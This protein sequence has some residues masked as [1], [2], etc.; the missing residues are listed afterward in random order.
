MFYLPLAVICWL[1]M[2]WMIDL[3][4]LPR[5]LP[6]GLLGS[7]LATVHDRMVISYKLWEYRDNGWIDH[8]TEIAL[9]ISFSA[10]PIFGMRFAERL[11]HG[12]PFPW[13]R[14]LRYTL[15]AM[16]PEVVALLTGR[17][18]YHGWWN[19]TWSIIAYYPIWAAFWGL[20]RWLHTPATAS[21]EDKNAPG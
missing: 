9:L 18:V 19:V 8:H 1:S 6:Y 12:A 14:T 5:L 13:G 16:I 20:H 2:P 4:E 15:I 11:E 21:R 10:A 3:R 7:V 17:I